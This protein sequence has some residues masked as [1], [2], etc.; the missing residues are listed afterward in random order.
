MT[1]RGRAALSAVEPS[2][3]RRTSSSWMIF[4]ICWPGVTPFRTS[5][6]AHSACTFSTNSLATLKWTSAERSAARTSARA[7]AMFSSDNFP[8]PRRFLSAEDSLSVRESNMGTQP[9]A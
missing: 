7:A 4:T 9:D 5:W 2:P 1:L 6:P 8:T 3:R